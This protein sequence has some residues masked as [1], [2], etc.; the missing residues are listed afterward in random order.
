MCSTPILYEIKVIQYLAVLLIDFF[1]NSHRELVHIKSS[2]FSMYFFSHIVQHNHANLTLK[3]GA[4][5][6]I[7]GILIPKRLS[8]A[9]S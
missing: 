7:I 5:S 4:V 1:L 9:I 2:M 3:F 8:I 6:K